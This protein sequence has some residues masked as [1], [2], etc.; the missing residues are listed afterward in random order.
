MTEA[1]RSAGVDVSNDA[2][3]RAR[4]I[5]QIQRISSTAKA[6]L[7]AGRTSYLEAAEYCHAMRNQVME[8]YR[9]LTSVQGLARAKQ[10]KKTPPSLAALFERYAQQLFDCPYENLSAEQQQRIHHEVIEASGRSNAEL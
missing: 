6:D 9:K 8:E 10:I 4:Y 5:S 7:S 3:T 2:H 1:E